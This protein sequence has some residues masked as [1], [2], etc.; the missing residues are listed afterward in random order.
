MTTSPAG[1]E[2]PRVYAVR[3]SVRA[4]DQV[5]QEHDRLGALS[6]PEI[7]DAWEDGLMET[8]MGLATFPERCALAPEDAVFPHETLRQLLYRRRRG[9][10]TWRIL[11]SVREA[12]AS[13]PPMIWVHRVRHGAQAPMTEWPPDEDEP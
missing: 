12:N 9:G 2:A 4:S 5:R 7:A 1:D 3:L 13:D 8:L 11:F 10:P 6:G